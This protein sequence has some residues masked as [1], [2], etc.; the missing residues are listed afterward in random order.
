MLKTREPDGPDAT[1]SLKDE[2]LHTSTMGTDQD[3]ARY[4]LCSPAMLTGDHARGSHGCNTAGYEEE[5]TYYVMVATSWTRESYCLVTCL[6]EAARCKEERVASRRRGVRCNCY[7][8]LFHL[9][10][11][12]VSPDLIGGRMCAE[13]CR[14]LYYLCGACSVWGGCD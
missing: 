2:T 8:Q 1:D 4:S 5:T 12:N 13:A 14:R 10:S 11:P 3:C 7:L 6:D 9:V